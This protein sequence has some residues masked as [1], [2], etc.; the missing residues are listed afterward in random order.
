MRPRTAL[1][2]LAA[3]C[4]V[5]PACARLL[6]IEELPES[7]AGGSTPDAG[8]GGVSDA[9]DASDA[10]DTPEAAP[11]SQCAC[12]ATQ[13]WT[14]AFPVSGDVDVAGVVV[15]A[16]DHIL[17][18]G[19]VA[20]D[21]DVGG[22]KLA[23]GPDHDVFVVA[24]AACGEVL[25]ARRF[26]N[27]GEQN[28]RAIAVDPPTS[29]HPGAVVVTGAFGGTLSFGGSASPLVATGPRAYVARLDPKTGDGIAS[30]AL[31]TDT[32]AGTALAVAPTG[33]VYWAGTESANQ[34]LFLRQLDPTFA[35]TSAIEPACNAC[36]PRI[37]LLG[38]DA[39]LAGGFHG[40]VDFVAGG[41]GPLTDTGAG[42]IY[43]AF[44]EP[45]ATTFI[46][47]K[48]QSFGDPAPQSA[49]GVALDA[50]GR[51]Y[52][53]GAFGG[54]LN[55]G[56]GGKTKISAGG[57]DAFVAKLDDTLTPQW[58]TA[59]GSSG[60]Q[61]ATAIA[62]GNRIA[63]V[64]DYADALDLGPNAGSPLPAAGYADAFLV[65]LDPTTGAPLHAWSF[66]TA[67]ADHGA[68]VA[69][70]GSGAAVVAGVLGGPATFDCGT[71]GGPGTSV[72]V[73]RRSLP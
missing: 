60:D 1:T 42:D 47:G 51:I 67:G 57:L 46:E 43:A 2:A 52:L 36:A 20:G 61:R 65:A 28:V 50:T 21:L 58:L 55:L 17:L 41:P 15:D 16:N 8:T 6:G 59:L 54:T 14:L 11:P 48:T 69:L 19:T 71:V 29:P 33:N 13:D 39:I 37:A 35:V 70:D 10:P 32:T 3:A 44:L 7:G 9:S 56:A 4:L 27:L 66:G 53:A 23:G 40:S 26:G 49:T 38:V 68:G 73:A 12:P 62:A 72:F 34:V 24:L 25:W 5:A 31:D 18:A 45:H 64:G 63:V 30:L 22:Q